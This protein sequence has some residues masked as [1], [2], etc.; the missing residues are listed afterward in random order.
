MQ[1]LDAARPGLEQDPDAEEEIGRYLTQEEDEHEEEQGDHARPREQEEI[2]AEHGRDGAAR[3]EV[4][5]LRVDGGAEG[6]RHERLERGR[7]KAAQEVE[8]EVAQP[9]ERVLDVVAEDP[10]EEHVPGQVE[11]VPVHEHRRDARER[12][13]LA[14]DRTGVVHLARVVGQVVDGAFGDVDAAVLDDDVERDVRRNQR[15]GHD[16]EAPGRDVVLERD[17]R[18]VS[19]SSAFWAWRRFSASSQTADWGP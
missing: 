14:D 15:R 7:S 5:D 3:S 17:Q 11:D 1:D 10:E 4:R 19:A 13:V 18:T 2:G 8:D 9:A 16:R 12:P 6:E